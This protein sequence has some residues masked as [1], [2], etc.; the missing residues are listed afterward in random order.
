MYFTAKIGLRMRILNKYVTLD[1]KYETPR[2]RNIGT[3][4]VPSMSAL[5]SVPE[6]HSAVKGK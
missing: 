3:H 2:E 1:M 5:I 6:I 4:A